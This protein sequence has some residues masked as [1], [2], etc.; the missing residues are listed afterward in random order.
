MKGGKQESPSRFRLLVGGLTLIFNTLMLGLILLIVGFVLFATGLDRTQHDPEGRAD[1]ITVLTGGKA[2]I[3]EAMRLLSQGKAKRVL[4]TGVH[5]AT[6]KK[7]L[8]EFA[9][10]GN[11]LFTCCV[12]IDHEARNTIDNAAETREWVAQKRYR[13]LIVVTSNY[14]MPRAL[15]ELGRAMPGVTLIPYSVVDNNVR[16]ERWWLY[17]GTTKLLLSEYLKYLPALGRLGVTHLVRT[18][19]SGETI[20]EK[21]VEP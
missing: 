17:P 21:A 6:T 13:S 14:H 10:E 2:R 16:L 8:K 12:D 20:A 1:G 4:I 5:R 9:Q 15:A 18:L 3:A 19:M 7:T 11:Q